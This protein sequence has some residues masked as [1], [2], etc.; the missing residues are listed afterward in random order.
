MKGAPKEQDLV[1]AYDAY[2]DA[3]FR[4]CYFKV[5]D[6]ELAQDMMQD[7]FLKAWA[8]MQ[9][10][11]DITNIRALLYRMADNLV[12]DWYRKKKASSLDAMVEEG[13]EPRDTN[14]TRVEERAEVEHALAK[15]HTLDPE[16][17]KL[18]TWRCVEDYTPAEIAAM[19]GENENTVSVRL[20]R[21]LKQLR[22]LLT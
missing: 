5:S 20:H 12:I 2:A 8:Y 6:R 13:F 15:L 16:D 9:N 7:V 22:A 11:T 17:Q 19:L 3:I 1:A 18:I 4:H 10:E 14:G 21:A